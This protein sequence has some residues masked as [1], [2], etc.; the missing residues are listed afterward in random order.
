M[1]L[2]PVSGVFS[3]IWM[4]C[5][6]ILWIFSVL[7]SVFVLGVSATDSLAAR[8]DDRDPAVKM[9]DKQLQT[10]LGGI[11][12]SIGYPLSDGSVITDA[13]LNG[14]IFEIK[15]RM[16]ILSSELPDP[17]FEERRLILKKNFC[18]GETAKLIENDVAWVYS[19][20]DRRGRSITKIR[21]DNCR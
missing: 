13:R 16:T 20:F 1:V 19:Y 3:M 11:K 12:D 21:I 8:L 5:R 9:I 10:I 17:S 7:G 18:Q 15:V 2:R 4:R 14:R 6:A